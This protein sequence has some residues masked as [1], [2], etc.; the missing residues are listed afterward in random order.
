MDLIKILSTDIEVEVVL[1]LLV[2]L[3]TDE[4]HAAINT[5]LNVVEKV[6]V[7]GPTTNKNHFFMCFF[8]K[9]IIRYI[10]FTPLG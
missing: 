10:N 5:K 7:S 9:H 2:G 3:S 6:K 1:A 8:T 4:L